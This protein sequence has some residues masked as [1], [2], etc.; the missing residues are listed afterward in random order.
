MVIARSDIDRPD[1]L[2]PAPYLSADNPISPKC[3]FRI[4]TQHTKEIPT[5]HHLSRL[6]NGRLAHSNYSD[7][8][9]PFCHSTPVNGDEIHYLGSS[10]SPVMK[11]M[12]TPFKKHL[13]RLTL[14]SWEELHDTI[15]ISLLLGS[16]L[17]PE[18]DNRKARRE[19]WRMCTVG[20][21]ALL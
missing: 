19:Q 9:C 5:H 2:K 10:I 13:K 4:R 7:R 18:I 14:P 11:P 15:K 20:T 21:I 6:T 8:I 16:S 3:L 1:L 17:N 12:Y